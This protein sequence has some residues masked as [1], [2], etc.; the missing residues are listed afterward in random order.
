MTT[1]YREIYDAEYRVREDAPP[2]EVAPER[3]RVRRWLG[4]ALT[5]LIFVATKLKFVFTLLKSVKFL[6]T[7]VTALISVG[8]YALWFGWQFAVGL[9]VLIFIHEMGHV[10]ALR[11]RPTRSFRASRVPTRKSR[12]CAIFPHPTPGRARRDVLSGGRYAT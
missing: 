8:G 6:S 5:A 1:D 2:A 12:I 11:R 7:G 4:M 3:S 9:V 10:V